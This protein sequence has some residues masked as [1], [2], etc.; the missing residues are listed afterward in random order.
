M[1]VAVGDVHGC[2]QALEKLLPVLMEADKVVFL[3]DYIDRGRDSVK[4]MEMV[5]EIP[6]AV[7]LKGNHEDMAFR[8]HLYVKDM[9]KY[10][11]GGQFDP[12]EYRWFYDKL[13]LSHREETAAGTYY[14]SH[15]GW[16]DVFRPLENQYKLSQS[17]PEVVEQSLLWTREH[18]AEPGYSHASENWTDGIAVF[19]HTP[20]AEPLL[21]KNMVGIDTGCVFGGKLTAVVLPEQPGEDYVVY[22]ERALSSDG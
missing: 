2:S 21:A 17:Q 1:I 8:S 13:V 22:Q 15:A 20:L 7:L 6:H 18:L 4:V 10:N 3:G 14:F 19:G 11:G 12:E 5:S 16:E 9:W